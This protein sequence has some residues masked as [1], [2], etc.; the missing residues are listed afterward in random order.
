MLSRSEEFQEGN[1]FDGDSSEAT[2]SSG[3]IKVNDT[4]DDLFERS[5]DMEIRTRPH[6]LTFLMRMMLIK[7][8]TLVQ[9]SPQM[10]IWMDRLARLV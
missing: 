4:V 8:M 1:A 5:I 2:F 7:K 6:W 10:T 9:W 3:P